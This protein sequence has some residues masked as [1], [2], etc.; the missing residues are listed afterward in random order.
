MKDNSALTSKKRVTISVAFRL[1]HRYTRAANYIF[2]RSRTN[3]ALSIV[4]LAEKSGPADVANDDMLIS[5]LNR[6]L[7]DAVIAPTWATIGLRADYDK[8]GHKPVIEGQEVDPLMGPLMTPEFNLLNRYPVVAAP[9]GRARNNVPTGMQI[10]ANGYDDLTAFRIAAAY[11][12]VAPPLFVGDAFPDYR[13]QE[14]K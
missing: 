1:P 9:T 3:Y 2:I 10:I 6:R 8:S 4:E 5:E 11:S 14:V 7:Q 13:D 12:Q